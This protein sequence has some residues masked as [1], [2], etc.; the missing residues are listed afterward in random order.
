MEEKPPSQPVTFSQS[1][2]SQKVPPS[3]ISNPQL[4]TKELIPDVQEPTPPSSDTLMMD[5]RPESDSHQV[6]ERPFQAFA[7]LPSVSL[8]VEEEMKSQS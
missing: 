7:E 5:P 1:A 6:L 8:L 2:E 3:A 4:E